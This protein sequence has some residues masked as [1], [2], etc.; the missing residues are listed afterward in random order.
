MEKK[1]FRSYML[2]IAFAVA[3]VLAIT[4]IDVLMGGIGVALGLLKP[5][6]IGFAIAFVLMFAANLNCVLFIFLSII[7]FHNLL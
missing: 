2:L 7:I 5:F 6:F 4:K 1:L 3:L